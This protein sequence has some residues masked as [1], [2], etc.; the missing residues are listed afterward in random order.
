MLED[1]NR[2][3]EL[4][5]KNI[6]DKLI[7]HAAKDC[8]RAEIMV[9]WIKSAKIQ[10]SRDLS[11]E[12]DDLKI[13]LVQTFENTELKDSDFDTIKDCK[14]YSNVHGSKKMIYDF[15]NNLESELGDKL[16]IIDWF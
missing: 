16:N 2:L 4:V 9:A 1:F 15:Y 10:T 14:F 11:S 5:Y 13:L 7:V 3:K 8:L 6:K 12:L